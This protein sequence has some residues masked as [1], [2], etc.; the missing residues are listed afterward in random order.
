MKFLRA[1]KDAFLIKLF[2]VNSLGVILR[3]F[4]GFISQKLI[5]IY[6][7]PNGIAL[8][9]NLR[10]AFT[11]FSL[12]ATA[13]VDQGVLKYQSEFD[14]DPN[15]LKKLYSTS[16][17]Y[18]VLGSSLAFIILCFGA[19]FWSNYLFQTPEY[20]YLFLILSFALPFTAFYNFVFAVI[21]GK[22]NYKKATL[23]SFLVYAIVTLLVI[24]LVVLYGLSGV[25]LAVT[26]TPLSQILV[27]V[28][29]AKKEIKLFF[30][31]R[32]RFHEFFRTKL[33][34]FITMSIAAVVLANL[35]ELQLRNHLIEKLSI[36]EAGYWTSMLS[37]SNYYLSFLTGVYSLYVLPKYAKINSL[38]LFKTELSSIYK[39]II[40]VFLVMFL[41][42]Y[43]FRD[44]VIQLLYTR[45]F[46][47]MEKLF[48]WQLL[49]DLV[50][51]VAVIMAYQF[52][53]KSLWK[54]FIIT[55][56]IS[57]VL[58]YIFGVYFVQHMGVEGIVFAHFIRYVLYLAII[59]FMLPSTFKSK[60]NSDEI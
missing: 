21:N 24:A 14:E 47:P 54:H 51:I 25:L 38:K 22:S 53:A 17:A 10:N 8:V 50:K 19:D 9:G 37:L 59:I 33:L 2:S 3:T 56:V 1:H 16:M 15:L 41:G 28:L 23:I 58:F 12:G 57:Y 13:G 46:L 35:V 4:L 55:E 43:F 34:S 27:L 52:I 42:I 36:E 30:N 40:P 49:G 20:N 29:F 31:L 6:L 44:F 39:I 26:L 18:G 45:E 11:L 32:I 7:G 5:A 48:K 60:E